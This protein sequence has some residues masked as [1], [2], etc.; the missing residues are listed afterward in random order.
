MP[1]Y[2]AFFNPYFASEV[3]QESNERKVE[4]IIENRWHSVL[5]LITKVWKHSPTDRLKD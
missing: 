4:K 5:F 1:R 2:R 3:F